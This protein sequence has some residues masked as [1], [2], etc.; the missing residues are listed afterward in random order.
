MERRGS[1]GVRGWGVLLAMALAVLLAAPP[2]ALAGPPQRAANASAGV[3][4][5]ATTV[6]PTP[7]VTAAAM[8]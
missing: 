1:N 8:D 2:H 4:L 7:S 6:A 3:A 5:A